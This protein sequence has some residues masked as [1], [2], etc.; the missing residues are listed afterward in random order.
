MASPPPVIGSLS[1]K[2][3]R[4]GFSNL[5][6]TSHA[7]RL[8]GAAGSSESMG[9][10]EG[11]ILARLVERTDPR[12]SEQ[13][14]RNL[15]VLLAEAGTPRGEIGAIVATGYGR[16]LVREATQVVELF[17]ELRVWP[18]QHMP[19][20]LHRAQH[21]CQ[22]LCCFFSP[23]RAPPPRLSIRA[24]PCEVQCCA[25]YTGRRRCRTCGSLAGGPGRTGDGV[26]G[27]RQRN[28]S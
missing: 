3:V 8:A 28:A 25:I 11:K 24:E 7:L 12:M 26:A 5:E 19:A 22:A 13:S 14:T 27:P 10:R 18:S 9:T 6:S 21:S 20:R 23:P 15:E 16:K 4:N 17:P 2:A 1:L